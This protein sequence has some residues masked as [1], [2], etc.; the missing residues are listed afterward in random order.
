MWTALVFAANAQDAVTL[1]AVRYAQE[2][3]SQPSVTFHAAVDGRLDVSLTCGAK[4]FTLASP[5]AAG[6]DYTI[7]L[8]GLSRGAFLCKGKLA[9]DAS[10]GTSGEMPLSIGVEVFA[11]LKLTVDR[12][13]LDLVHHHLILRGDRPLG[14][15]EV[16]V[17]GPGS[18]S[19]VGSATAGA[20]GRVDLEWTG[21]QE[22]VRLVVTGWDTH[23]L[24]S[25]LELLPWSYA[26][27]HEDVVFASDSAA[28]DATELPK[29]EKAWSEVQAVRT[30]YGA[31]VPIKLFV[32]GYTDTVGD[33]AHNAT[34]SRDRA[35]ALAAW[36]RQRGF[37]GPIAY[38]G[39]GEGALA[40]ATADSVD[41]A[42]NRRAIYL[43]AAETPSLSSDVPRSDWATAP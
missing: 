7:P 9:L 40:V 28:I 34:L 32:G 11:P 6:S 24:P 19:G 26:I 14:R 18:G 38:Q 37:D 10:D 42:R 41:E 16:T 23:D 29:L 2:G 39:F 33:A 35:K 22:P 31:L 12:A 27:P 17:F 4:S 25:S 30:K 13:D 36:F 15:A 3:L 21:D 20:D 5:I 43:L 1:S 8:A